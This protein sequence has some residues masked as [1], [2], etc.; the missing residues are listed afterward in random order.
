MRRRTAVAVAAVAVPAVLATSAYA[1]SSSSARSSRP[2]YI[3]TQHA[4][5]IGHFVPT[6]AGQ[7]L[8][9]R[10]ATIS[11]NWAGWA[12]LPGTPITGVQSNFTVPAAKYTPAGF[13][14]SWAGIG[15]YNT[16]DLIQ[17]G[18]TS[19]SFGLPGLPRY[20]AWFEIL[21]DSERLLIN[22]TGDR[23]CTVRPGDRMGVDIH[24]V[25][26]NLWSVTVIDDT[27]WTWQMN[28][29]YVSSRSSAE[30]ILEAP[31]VGAQTTI[32]QVGAAYFGTVNNFTIGGHRHTIAA[33][34]P[35]KINL[36]GFEA[37]TSNLASN[38]QSFRVC[39]YKLRCAAP[40]Y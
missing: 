1:T 3:A 15:G 4:A 6:H 23:N 2:S 29:H 28:V 21:P 19:D 11:G 38:R 36:A 24:S 12:V 34:H 13:S 35:V 26:T 7:A 37:I 39:T 5:R 31:T 22:C 20:Y 27:H 40:P 14:A 25:G 16:K 30:W 32:A 18:T 10:N 8:P 9:R 17:A 33:G